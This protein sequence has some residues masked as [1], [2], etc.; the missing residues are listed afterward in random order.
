MSDARSLTGRRALVTGAT[1]GLGLEVARALVARGLEVIVAARSPERGR[2]TVAELRAT[3][4]DVRAQLLE[5]ELGDRA[6]VARA[7]AEAHERL[8]RLD[9]LVANAGVMAI[10]AAR[11][12]DGVE[13]TMAVNHLGHAQLIWGL[14]ELLERGHDPRVVT[15]TSL[16]HRVGRLD[17]AH[18]ARG[19]V[20]YRRGG[21]YAASKLANLVFALELER[22]LRARGLATRSLGAH[23]GAVA[24]HLGH[25][26]SGW[27]NAVMRSVAPRVL[28]GPRRGARPLLRAA[29]DASLP[30]GVLVGPAGLVVGPPRVER[31]AR[32]ALSLALGSS[33]W[34]ATAAL[35]GDPGF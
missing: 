10:D 31:P 23:P 7:I 28:P 30:G 21:A 24:T 18:L 19:P 13:L 25:E 27:S 22:R 35:V 8:D 17:P 2:A 20:P 4:S 33:L 5:V 26:G 6:S 3:G 14:L 29:L 12:V 11:S 34:T 1:S 16:V 9:L 32:R 15:V